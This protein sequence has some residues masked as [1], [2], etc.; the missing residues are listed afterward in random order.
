LQ[1]ETLRGEDKTNKQ[2]QKQTNKNLSCIYL[3]FSTWDNANL[4]KERLTKE[5]HT[6]LFKRRDIGETFKK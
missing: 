1:K 3:H 6:D 5:K 2:Q 4:N